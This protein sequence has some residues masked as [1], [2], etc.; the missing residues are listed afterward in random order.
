MSVNIDTP[1]IAALKIEVEKVVGTISGH[2]KFVKLTELIES[3]CK[4]HISVTTL[5]RLWG[6]STRSANRI[7]ERILDIIA[8]FVDAKSWDDF[9]CKLN[10]NRESI[11]FEGN[12]IINCDSLKIGSRIRLGWKP[13]RMCEVEYL[14]N[15]RFVATKVENSTIR[16]G[17]TFRCLQIQKGRELHM[18]NFTR[19]NEQ[20]SSCARYIVGRTNGL[21]LLEYIAE[22]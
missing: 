12:D 5:E 17:D 10:G 4:E 9:C 15:Y 22:E 16:S 6:Y 13:D 19:C 21:T 3:K 7:S 8:R 2:D 14:V 1:L 11:L 18:D 20:E